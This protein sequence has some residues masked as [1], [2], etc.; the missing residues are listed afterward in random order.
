MT[1]TVII[2]VIMPKLLACSVNETFALADN[3]SL[4][5]ASKLLLRSMERF[6][7]GAHCLA[8]FHNIRVTLRYVPRSLFVAAC[9]LNR[10]KGFGY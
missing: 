9:L 6:N 3:C 4:C 7:S 2:W 5:A 10:R 8:F 1:D